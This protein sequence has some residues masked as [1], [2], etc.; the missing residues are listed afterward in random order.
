MSRSMI[1]TDLL[2]I[3]GWS[4]DAAGVSIEGDEVIVHVQ[5]QPGTGYTCSGCGQGLLFAYDHYPPRR[6][7]DFPVWGRRTFLELRVARVRC[8]DCGV[9]IER[10][11]WLEKYARQTLRYEKYVAHLCD[12]LPVMDVAELEGLDKNTVYRVDRKWLNRREALRELRPVKHL[13]IDE[14]ALRKGHKYATVFYDLERREVIG[15]VKK[16]RE[17]AVSGFFRRWG[18]TN[19]RAVQAVCMDLWQPFLNSVR[20]H[21]K[22]AVVVFDKFHV[23]KYLS[24]AIEEVRRHEQDICPDEQGKLIKG[25]RWLW[26]RSSD[27]LRRKEKQTLDEIMAINRNLQKA[28][29][30]KEDFADFYTCSSRTE[31]ESFIQGWL[32]RC[33]QSGMQGFIKLAQ[34]IRRWLHGI[35]AYFEHRI[36]NGVSEGINNKIKVLKRRSYGFHDDQY[37]FLKILNITGALPPLE[38][39]GHPRL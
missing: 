13:G 6:V 29:L 33:K 7:R 34:R 2:C 22:N 16:R 19:C 30:L 10:L 3:Q 28:Y 39:L 32:R 18:K 38:A 15:L 8:P 25:T 20:R 27:H 31:A 1:V 24:D 11:D 26:L 14:I 12:L 21:C 4:V 37:F 23:F 35:L 17:R 9:M 36:T 5:R